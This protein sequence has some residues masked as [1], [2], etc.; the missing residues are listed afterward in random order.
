[1]TFRINRIY[2]MRPAVIKPLSIHDMHV[3]FSSLSDS[4]SGLAFGIQGIDKG[5][6]LGNGC[7]N[8]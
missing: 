3:N 4:L 5:Q 1:M 8:F 6:K 2:P 7:I